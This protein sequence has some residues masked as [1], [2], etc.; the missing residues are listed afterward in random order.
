MERSG[1]REWREH[2][3]PR[4]PEPVL[5]EEV[6]ASALDRSVW[7]E[8]RTLSKD[9][10]EGVARHLVATAHF[11]AEEDL[12]R[13]LAHAQTAGRRAGRVASVREALGMVHYRRGEW[14]K[15][16]GEFR[17]ARR[18]SGSDHLLPLLADVERG[19]GRPERALEL[20]ASAEATRLAHTDR[21]ELAIVVS[22]ARRDL[23]QTDAAVQTLRDLVRT[24]RPGQESA[25]RLAYAY[26]DALAADG[27]PAGAREW[28]STALDLD[29]DGSTDAAERLAELD[30]I[31]IIDL[32]EQDAED[33]AEQRP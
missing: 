6:E 9:N 13:A 7:Q 22:G 17:T 21:I 31:E 27:D 23:G 24:I 30:G 15:A 19:L 32:V 18:L 10:A 2:R 11:L 25:V 16:L 8:L 20:A 12:D 4:V 1:D 29:R 33:D 3:P 14:S 28:F 26:A 5:P